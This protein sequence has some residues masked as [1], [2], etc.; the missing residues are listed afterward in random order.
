MQLFD[1]RAEELND[2]RA[3]IESTVQEAIG[4]AIRRSMY[5][6]AVTIRINID[7]DT[8]TDQDG[9]VTLEPEYEY[10]TSYRIGG[11]YGGKTS[12]LKS[13]IGLQMHGPGVYRQVRLA[14]QVSMMEGNT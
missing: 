4:E 5:H 1:L 2:L 6:S 11:Q 9:V 3:E 13:P 14:E 10:K 12:K 7:L 8:S